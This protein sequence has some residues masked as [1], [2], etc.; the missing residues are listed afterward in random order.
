MQRESRPLLAVDGCGLKVGS[1]WV[2]PPT[3]I[4][5][6]AG[7]SVAV[8]GPSGSGK[9][10]LLKLIAG[11]IRPTT[12]RATVCDVDLSS[13]PRRKRS[14]QTRRLISLVDQDPG[15]LPE[16]SVWEN[17]ALPLLLDRVP[18]ATAEQDAAEALSRV[19]LERQEGRSLAHLSGG[20]FQRAAV[21]RAWAH[22]APLVLADEPTAS[23]DHGNA[24]TVAS[25]LVDLAK[26]SRDRCLLMATHD[27]DVASLCDRI[28]RLSQQVE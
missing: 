18:A 2:L 22:P 12:G 24:M 9:T 16:L 21:A 28:V 11:R 23:L 8:M 17:V 7:E 27:A 5:I 25:L 19:G 15:L 14:Q 4:D 1:Q 10:T 3:S 13:L 26:F 6:A 20:E